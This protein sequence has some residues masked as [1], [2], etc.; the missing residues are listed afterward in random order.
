MEFY[1]IIQM[2]RIIRVWRI[3]WKLLTIKYMNIRIHTIAKALAKVPSKQHD[4]TAMQKP[5][6][7]HAQAIICWKKENGSFED[8]RKTGVGTQHWCLCLH[9]L[10]GTLSHGRLSQAHGSNIIKKSTTLHS[11]CNKIWFLNAFS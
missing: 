8:R 10:F 3:L 1:R 7:S 5:Y 6:S 9:F 4:N 2:N 11:S